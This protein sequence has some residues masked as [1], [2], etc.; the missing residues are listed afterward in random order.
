V[1]QALGIDVAD[2]VTRWAVVGGG[3]V[4]GSGEVPSVATVGATVVAGA[5]GRLGEAEPVMVDGVPFGAEALVGRLLAAVLGDARARF[6]DLAVALVHA[7]DLDEY[8]RSLLVEAARVGEVAPVTMVPASTAN[9]ATPCPPDDP[10]A[11]AAGAAATLAEDE[12]AGAAF[13]AGG[14]A[15]GI[16]GGAGV[17]IGAGAVVAGADGATTTTAPTTGTGPVGT[18]LAP[19]GPSGTPLGPS[20][21]SLGPS[22]TPLGPSGTPLPA[23]RPKL[24]LVLAGAA[25]AVVVVVGAVIAVVGGGGGGD[26]G[27]EA[28][29]PADTSVPA[30]ADETGTPT[31]A[32]SDAGTD[33]PVAGSDGVDLNAYVG[34]WRFACEPYIDGSGGG[35]RHDFALEQTGTDALTLTVT[36]YDHTTDDCSDAGTPVI[37]MDYQLT[38]VE[39]TVVDGTPAIVVRDE[40]DGTAGLLGVDGSGS[41]QVGG[42]EGPDVPGAFDPE[43]SGRRG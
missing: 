40:G 2:D 4:L 31:T 15:A 17:G 29:A 32:P 12:P 22:G 20:G 6:G 42:F 36:G 39:T 9:A 21:T 7:D 37:S 14:I 11:A 41:L 38:V 27:V 10:C 1:T 34:S 35:S 24:P 3:R 5:V 25:V 33:T 23:A 28:V 16:A 8:R 30:P 26:G 43:N 19:A 13:A 18:P